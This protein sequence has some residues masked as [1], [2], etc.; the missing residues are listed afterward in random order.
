[1]SERPLVIRDLPVEE[2]PRER[3]ERYGPEALSNAELL[4]I[5]LRVG[6]EGESAVRMAE[7]LLVEL[8]GL[9]GIARARLP[10]LAE[11]KGM[12]LAKAA[13]LKAAVEL[14]KRIAATGESARPVL[15]TAALA[16]AQ[17]MEELRY[18]EQERLVALFLDNRCQ[19]IRKLTITVGTLAGSPAHPR[20]I[21]REA[22]AHSAA[23]VIIAH[24][25]PSGDPAPSR[26]DLALTERLVKAGELVGIP[27]VDHLIIGDGRWISLKESGRM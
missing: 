14:G 12:G 9:V 19:L 6:M 23:S 16:A 24:N 25:H 4:A 18:L 21:F 5:L 22:I 11:P 20:D 15:N 10:Q 17:L 8:G 7:R 2:R 1:M 26:D 13:Q 3:M 27:L